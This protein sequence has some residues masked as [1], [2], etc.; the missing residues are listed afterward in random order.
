MLDVFC[1]PPYL[2]RPVHFYCEGPSEVHRGESI[3][4]RCM[5][6]NRSPY[7]LETFIKLKG[8]AEERKSHEFV[9]ITPTFIMQDLTTTSSSMWKSTAT[10]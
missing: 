9:I 4:V 7:D 6:M 5:I 3:G 10:W 8:K 2:S 1:F